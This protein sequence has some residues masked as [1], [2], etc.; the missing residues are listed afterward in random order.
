V[1]LTVGGALNNGQGSIGAGTDLGIQAGSLAN[2]SGGSLRATHDVQVTA[3][4]A[5]TNAGSITA[6]RNT[7]VTAGS[8][9]SNTGSVLGAGI[10]ADGSLASAGDLNV[11]AT[12]GLTAQGTNLAA[13]NVS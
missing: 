10:Q 8:V 2:A 5:L 3:S 12:Q 7:T 11:T 6:G 13:G 4:G 1:Q 9:Q